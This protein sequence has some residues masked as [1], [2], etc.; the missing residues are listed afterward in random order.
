MFNGQ[1]E[2]PSHLFQLDE[3]PVRFTLGCYYLSAAEF[4]S[5]IKDIVA[6]LLP[7]GV[8]MSVHFLHLRRGRLF[9]GTRLAS[10]NTQKHLLCHDGSLLGYGLFDEFVD[11]RL[12][13]EE[14]IFGHSRPTFLKKL[15][16]TPNLHRTDK[17]RV[18]DA[19]LA[20]REEL[21]SIQPGISTDP[22]SIA[23]LENARMYW[24][25]EMKMPWVADS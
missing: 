12:M 13:D 21:R 3:W 20:I 1:S 15:P 2:A 4:P 5:H 16:T 18:L 7:P 22:N 9:A 6:E 8:E 14:P 23:Q 17:F 25:F 24:L 10:L 19:D 11:C